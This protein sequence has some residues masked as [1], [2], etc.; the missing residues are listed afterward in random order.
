LYRRQARYYVEHVVFLIHLHS[1]FL[2]LLA[3]TLVIRKFFGLEFF[4]KSF[5]LWWLL[6]GLLF[7]MRRFYQQSWSTT[8]L[9]WI[10]LSLLYLIS[11]LVVFML[12]LLVSLLVF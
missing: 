2:F 10:V 1:G 4:P 5:G 6:F 7:G 12:S 9:K 11:F 3:M 8:L